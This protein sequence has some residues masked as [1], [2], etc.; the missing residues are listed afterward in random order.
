MGIYDDTA[1]EGICSRLRVAGR[2]AVPVGVSVAFSVA[3]RSAQ[4][5]RNAVWFPLL[6]GV[7]FLVNL[8]HLFPM[9]I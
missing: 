1:I 7:E 4:G 6:G 5:G 3:F 9:V 8:K 2:T